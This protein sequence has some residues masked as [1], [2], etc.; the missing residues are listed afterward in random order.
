MRRAEGKGKNVKEVN[1]QQFKVFIGLDK[2]RMHGEKGACHGKC[3]T[4]R[5]RIYLVAGG[6]V[7]RQPRQQ[8]WLS[9]HLRGGPE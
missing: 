3:V 8:Q 5:G 2:A 9:R 4:G 1:A 7:A 6:T